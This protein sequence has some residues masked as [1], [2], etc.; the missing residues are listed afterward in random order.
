M[1]FKMVLVVLAATGLLTAGC[2]SSSDTGTSAQ[3]STQQQGSQAPPPPANEVKTVTI[4]SIKDIGS[5]IPWLAEKQGFFKEHGVD[6]T[7]NTDMANTSIVPSLVG[8]RIQGVVGTWPTIPLLVASGVEV[9]GV[10]NMVTVNKDDSLGAYVTANS[11]IKSASDLKGK[12]L[13]VSSLGNSGELNARRVVARAGLKRSDV[14]LVAIPFSEQP[15]ALRT[16]RIDAAMMSEPYVTLTQK[17]T[18]LRRIAP[19]AP[20]G[21]TIPIN[22]LLVTRAFADKNPE[23]VKR[24]QAAVAEGV[25]YAQDNPAA[26]RAA[27]TAYAGIAPAIASNPD[28]KLPIWSSA[29]VSPETLQGIADDMKKYGIIKKHVDVSR[30]VLNTAGSGS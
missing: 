10:A 9:L 16:G 27:L 8:G 7:I 4:A 25:K 23:T 18:K 3:P 24:L 29:P 26:V 22:A 12:T 14:K 13:A 19:A 1:R 28:L 30:N 20:D 21:E 2:G 15:V 5:M 6:V 11:P 17:D